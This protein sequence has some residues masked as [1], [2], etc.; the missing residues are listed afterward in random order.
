MT[1]FAPFVF[2]HGLFG[3]FADESAYGRLAPAGCSAPDLPGY[4]TQ[5]GSGAVTLEAQVGALRAHIRVHHPDQP[6]NLVAHSIGAVYAFAL[7]DSEP[8]LVRSVTSVEGN[9]SLA[10]AFWSRSIAEL[11]EDAA[12]AAIE[13][14][15][16]D[17]AAFLAADGIPATEEHLARAEQALAYQPWRT[18]WESAITIVAATASDRYENMMKRVFA[19]TP[20]Y[21]VAGERTAAAWAV[22]GWAK[23]AARGSVVL[24]G[25]GHMMML[26]KPED[27]GRCLNQLVGGRNPEPD[28]RDGR[29]SSAG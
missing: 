6:V 23:E 3:P 28:R 8:G 1:G 7:A 13:P 20:V 25:T 27:F 18:V 21:L 11:R 26:E 17:P 24:P 19:R 10:D 9:F 2:V 14:R 15:L 16:A 4:G 22:P 29:V 5:A 12:Q